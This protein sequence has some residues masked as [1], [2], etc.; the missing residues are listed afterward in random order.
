MC[1]AWTLPAGLVASGPDRYRTL[2]HPG[3]RFAF[4]IFS[5][6]G[7]ALRGGGQGSALG[8]LR[9]ERIVAVGES[10][11]AFFLTTYINAVH[12]IAPAFDG[13]FVHSRGGSG[14]SLTG[15]AMASPDVPKGLTIRSD[16]DVPVMIFETETDLGPLLD[17]GPA[18][19]VDTDR[20]RT[21]EV[22]G[23]AHADAYVVG[24]FAGV[25]GCDFAVN[26]G[27]QHFVAKAALVALNRW[28]TDSVAPATAS[29]LRLAT[30]DPPQLARDELGN[31][32]GGVRTPAVDVPI[33]ALSGEAP[34]GASRL[35]AL[36]GTTVPFN[37]NTLVRLYGDKPG[38]LDVYGRSLD[39]AIA[40]RFL[41]ESDRAQLQATAEA[42][43][44]SS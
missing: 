12:P 3:D 22:A 9:P 19:Q 38:Y 21:W 27:P 14:A 13:F 1:P 26:D 24:G 18:R 29:P 36:F 8:A 39:T 28:I 34:P 43:T 25:L 7:R 40:A 31:A 4:D 16:T 15:I 10:Q 6:I 23:T 37:S 2:R 11:S 35:C 42:V 17:Y 32:L 30:S 5:Q 33:S 41:L 44:F 20:I